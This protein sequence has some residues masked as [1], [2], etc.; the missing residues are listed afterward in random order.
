MICLIDG[1]SHY[2][3]GEFE[4]DMLSA[5]GFLL[6]LVRKYGI[7]PAIK[8]TLMATSPTM[9]DLVQHRLKDDDASFLSLAEVRN[10]G[11][12]LRLSQLE[13]TSES[14]QHS[15]SSNE[16]EDSEDDRSTTSPLPSLS[17]EQ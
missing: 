6:D 14:E 10:L 4:D 16:L 3:T 1:V 9:T 11:Q 15:C 2:K 13:N 7:T 17:V 8:L 5:L 12:E